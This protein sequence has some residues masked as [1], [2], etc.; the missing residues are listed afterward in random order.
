M[1]TTRFWPGIT[2]DELLRDELVVDRHSEPDDF[3]NSFTL[4]SGQAGPFKITQGIIKL[5]TASITS[6]TDRG[7]ALLCRIEATSGE[8]WETDSNAALAIGLKKRTHL[9]RYRDELIKEGW[10]VSAGKAYC[11]SIGSS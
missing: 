5:P 2:N 11:G 4:D 8:Y 3:V 7:A 1:I 6:L 9:K 10:I